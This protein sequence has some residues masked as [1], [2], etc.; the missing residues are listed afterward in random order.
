MLS[1]CRATLF[2]RSLFG[3]AL[4]FFQERNI[5]LHFFIYL[6]MSSSQNLMPESNSS[7]DHL[8]S[9]K[10]QYVDD[11]QLT[12]TP[13]ALIN[14]SPVSMGLLSTRGPPAWHPATQDIKYIMLEN[15]WHSPYWFICRQIG[16]GE[17]NFFYRAV[18]AKAAVYCTDQVLMGKIAFKGVFTRVHPYRAKT[19]Q[20]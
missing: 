20:T 16:R 10:T 9:S 12:S 3:Q 2:D 19:L 6:E 15:W 4:D 1:Y 5:G 11:D 13:P 17:L 18:C 8:L 7:F 14:A